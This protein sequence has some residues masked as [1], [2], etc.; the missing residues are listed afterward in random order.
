MNEIFQ[1]LFLKKH[2]KRQRVATEADS[3]DI[4]SNDKQSIIE[5]TNASHHTKATAIEANRSNK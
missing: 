1:C 4:G 5:S 3:D 2:S